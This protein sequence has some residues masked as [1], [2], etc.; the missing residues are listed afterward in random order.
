MIGRK[1]TRRYVNLPTVIVCQYCQGAVHEEIEESYLNVFFMNLFRLSRHETLRCKS[2]QRVLSDSELTRLPKKQTI[3]SKY[4]SGYVRKIQLERHPDK[5]V[6]RKQHDYR[7]MRPQTDN[8]ELLAET[9]IAI[10][11]WT[12]QVDERIELW[13]DQNYQYIKREYAT[14]GARLDILEDIIAGEN[15]EEGQKILLQKFSNCQDAFPSST[16][17]FILSQS[18]SVTKGQLFLDIKVEECF[19]QLLLMAG[20]GE[21]QLDSSLASFRTSWA[22]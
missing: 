14:Y 21:L 13:E 15:L 11:A 18:I 20:Y 9:I 8:D 22:N 1:T 7:N 5:V 2:C 16:L 6:E 4:D 10:M 17:N 12:A 3:E 19:K